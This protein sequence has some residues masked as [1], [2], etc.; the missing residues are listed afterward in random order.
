MW[1]SLGL[2]VLYGLRLAVAFPGTAL[3]LRRR[4]LDATPLPGPRHVPGA[5]PA[6]AEPPAAGAGPDALLS[7]L[8]SGGNAVPSVPEPPAGLNGHA[9]AAAEL[10]AAELRRGRGA[11]HPRYPVRAAHR[12]GQGQ[13]VQAYLRDLTRTP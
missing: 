11:G 9:H 3:G 6:G 8:T 4:L 7:W 2:A 1:R 13:Q 10:F 5:Y 12:P